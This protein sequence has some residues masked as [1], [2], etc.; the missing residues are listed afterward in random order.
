MRTPTIDRANRLVLT[1][2]G[3]V[4]TAAGTIGLLAR[5]GVIDVAEPGTLYRR[6]RHNV[7]DHADV[8]EWCAIA[9]GILLAAV[10]LLWAWRQV[11]PRGDGRISTTVVNHT[12]RGKTSVEPVAVARALA[13]DLQQVPGVSGAKVRMVSID[14]RPQLLAMVSIR[15]DA[16]PD[17]VRLRAEAPFARLCRAL[18]VD[19]VDVE[20]RL[21]PTDEVAARVI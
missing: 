6:V 17:D 10:A 16:D 9:G 14:T 13:K 21:R 8:W 18:E 19:A 3:L 4:L 7:V 11:R 1:L 12:G 15:D 2:V 20:L 5:N